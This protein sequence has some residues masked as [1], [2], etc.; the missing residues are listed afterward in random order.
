VKYILKSI[1]IYIKSILAIF[2]TITL[3]TYFNIITDKIGIKVFYE[4][5]S[6]ILESR[7]ILIY[8]VII[9]ISGV[10]LIEYIS[11]SLNV[12]KI[13]KRKFFHI[14]ALL[15]FYPGLIYLKK[16]FMLL[17]SIVVLYLLICIE[18]VR[19][20]FK[21]KYNNLISDYLKSNIDSR[22]NENMIITHILLLYSSFSSLLYI[23]L[24]S[25]N[26]KLKYI[27]LITL[28]IGDAFVNI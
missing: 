7:Y 18:I 15:I 20:K 1:S 16:D 12:K 13:V 28:C 14:L 6:N 19:N 22:D 23:S 3:N 21:N 5:Y 4:M 17:I 25:Q 11:N 10:C 27:G 26:D 8:W 2:I 9:L 24:Y